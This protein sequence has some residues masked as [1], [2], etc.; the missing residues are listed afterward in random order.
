MHHCH[1]PERLPPPCCGGDLKHSIVV[2]GVVQVIHAV[3]PVMHSL[4]APLL[5]AKL[6]AMKAR[7]ICEVQRAPSN[8]IASR[9]A[10]NYAF[11]Q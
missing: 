3:Q 10:K 2:A 6:V 9:P 4:R 1:V 7:H 11:S 8:G 5:D